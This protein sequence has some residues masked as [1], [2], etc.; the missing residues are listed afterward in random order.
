MNPLLIPERQFR[1]VAATTMRMKH[2]R[3]T[4][5]ST[6]PNQDNRNNNRKSNSEQQVLDICIVL[7]DNELKICWCNYSVL[8]RIPL[9]ASVMA[10]H[11]Q[12]WTE[13]P[14]PHHIKSFLPV[15]I[16]CNITFEYYMQLY[17]SITCN[18]TFITFFNIIAI[19]NSISCAILLFF[20]VS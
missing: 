18:I 6:K 20:K 4:G 5:K 19:Y 10:E 8:W 15:A 12:P 16:M 13:T 7:N 9:I 17:F 2:R 3:G 14:A 11:L 1:C